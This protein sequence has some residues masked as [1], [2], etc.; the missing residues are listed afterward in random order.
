VAVLNP[1]DPMPPTAVSAKADLGG[2]G[3]SLTATATM[4]VPEGW[5]ASVDG[6]AVV[7]IS[8][9]SAASAFVPNVV[10]NVGDVADLSDGPIQGHLL[11]ERRSEEG[12]ARRSERS[13][14]TSDLG[15]PVAQHA[16]TIEHAQHA[17]MSV[18]CSAATFDWSEVEP[19]F[20]SVLSS[21]ALVVEGTNGEA[22]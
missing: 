15:I 11:G 21:A 19:I 8:R 20:R 13:V 3:D 16:L 9:H 4:A 12:S 6:S 2:E 18:V 1:D 14:V 5:S 17:V 22:S 10:M 7:M